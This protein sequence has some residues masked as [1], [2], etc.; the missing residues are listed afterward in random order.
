M[1]S[2]IEMS[3]ILSTLLFIG[4]Q[5]FYKKNQMYVT[6]ADGDSVLT[7]KY[8]SFADFAP[9]SWEQWFDKH[10]LDPKENAVFKIAR[11]GNTPPLPSWQ[12]FS[13]KQWLV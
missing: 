5:S 6:A 9:L 12:K 10:A 3:I 4:F 8:F 13:N 7:T 11:L 1:L 2:C